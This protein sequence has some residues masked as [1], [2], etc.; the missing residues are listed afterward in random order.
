[1][2]D[3]ETDEELARKKQAEAEIFG[4]TLGFTHTPSP[5]ELERTVILNPINPPSEEPVAQD[6]ESTVRFSNF[7]ALVDSDSESASPS[8]SPA[9][10]S[11]ASQAPASQAST[12]QS[13]ASQPPAQPTP[14]AKPAPTSK[15]AAPA[16][17]QATTP[18]A[19]QA[20][21][22]ALASPTPPAAKPTPPVI[23]PAAE[24]DLSDHDF[25]SLDP[26]LSMDIVS[27][28]PEPIINEPPA[29]EPPAIESSSVNTEAKADTLA[30]IPDAAPAEV[31]PAGD[32]D[33]GA[34]LDELDELLKMDVP[35][36]EENPVSEE[37]ESAETDAP[38]DTANKAAAE[39]EW[40]MSFLEE[41]EKDEDE[42]Y[43]D[44][45]DDGLDMTVGSMP[46]VQLGAADM[47]MGDD[48]LS[49]IDEEDDELAK[50]SI[51][52]QASDAETN[53]AADSQSDDLID[54]SGLEASLETD[55][56]QKA[57]TSAAATSTDEGSIQQES[58][59]SEQQTF[60]EF[61]EE[62]PAVSDLGE[63]EDVVED[64]SA[65]A[66]SDVD[67]AAKEEQP[68]ASESVQV[69]SAPV[70]ALAEQVEPA[71]QEAVS[72]PAEQKRGGSGF[73]IFL[74]LLALAG[75]GASYWFSQ[76]PAGE[77]SQLE[78]ELAQTADRVSLLE[79]NNRELG[80]RINAL[81]Q[82]NEELEQ[83]LGDLTR[84]VA[85]RSTAAQKKSV[86]RKTPVIK[87]STPVKPIVKAKTE[88]KTPTVAKP[89]G[90]VINLT[91]VSSAE[92]AQQEVARLQ[93]LGVK[94]QSIRTEARGKIWYRI[95]VAGFATREE[96][97]AQ[98]ELLGESLNIPDIWVGKP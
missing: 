3:K 58:Q 16:A 63:P 55:E 41:N 6:F 77:G 34:A 26:E 28:E 45:K 60:E 38:A 36:I 72:P 4:K 57:E 62:T 91:S 75:A 10:Q 1:M 37:K 7:D 31:T 21:T 67:K 51:N 29:V 13:P 89:K 64:D 48:L 85:N 11:P 9:P 27:P 78:V 96:A 49:P 19:P 43:G 82:K 8:Q 44:E 30:G 70:A 50:A 40:D 52:D 15:P 65:E 66:E 95:R 83:Q 32:F 92:S 17:P 86:N 47:T 79:A 33:S 87:P 98:A 61:E 90:W 46:T 68:S 53:D 24:L 23:P 25:G 94:A 76:G 74:S 5:E 69:E 42:K 93:L 97:Q 54:L 88:A 80:T 84:V 59:G 56:D 20:K 12:P 39:P 2:A 35:E 14:A 73:A 71:A 22:A 18:Q 81:T